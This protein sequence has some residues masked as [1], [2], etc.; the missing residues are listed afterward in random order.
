MIKTMYLI[1]LL[2]ASN[3]TLTRIYKTGSQPDER[4][5]TNMSKM[6][7]CKNKVST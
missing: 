3:A 7:L 6:K 5:L 2:R 1:S 4:Y